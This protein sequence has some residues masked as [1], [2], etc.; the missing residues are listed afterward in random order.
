MH[1][2]PGRVAHPFGGAQRRLYPRRVKEIML[3]R[4]RSK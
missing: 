2:P 4:L 1:I 3:N